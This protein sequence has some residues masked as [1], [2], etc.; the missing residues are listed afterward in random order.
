MIII[1]YTLLVCT[2]LKPVRCRWR[3]LPWETL[4]LPSSFLTFTV[5]SICLWNIFFN[6]NTAVFAQ[7]I[8]KCANDAPDIQ[9]RVVTLDVGDINAGIKFWSTS[10][11]YLVSDDSHSIRVEV[12]PIWHDAT[13]NMLTW[14]EMISNIVKNNNTY[15]IRSAQMPGITESKWSGIPCKHNIYLCILLNHI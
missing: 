4:V 11:V 5:L 9:R 7:R 6:C 8:W 15:N 12:L 1:A 13:F 10:H 2:I 14:K 3:R